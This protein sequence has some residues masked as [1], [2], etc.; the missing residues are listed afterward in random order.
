MLLFL[1]MKGTVGGL[2]K[3]S[4]KFHG[5]VLVGIVDVRWSYHHGAV[6]ANPCT[7]WVENGNVLVPEPISQDAAG[8]LYSLG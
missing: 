1:M 4:W 6:K 3:Y 8:N 2:V 5:S 7:R